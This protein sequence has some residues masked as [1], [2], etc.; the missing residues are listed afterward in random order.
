LLNLV[1]S[2]EKGWLVSPTQPAFSDRLL[3]SPLLSS[4]TWIEI[5]TGDVIPLATKVCPLHKEIPLL[6]AEEL[7]VVD[8]ALG[9]EDPMARTKIAQWLLI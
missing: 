8:P 3:I 5:G 7:V 9:G 2:K 1:P 4:I 6:V